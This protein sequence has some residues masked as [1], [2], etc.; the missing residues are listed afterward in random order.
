MLRLARCLHRAQGGKKGC[1]VLLQVGHHF[2]G[3][4]KNTGSDLWQSVYDNNVELLVD[5]VL[6]DFKMEDKYG[7]CLGEK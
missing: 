4:V 6:E 5:G 1:A 7:V 2:L 3:L